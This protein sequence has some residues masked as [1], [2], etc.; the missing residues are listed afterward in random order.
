MPTMS[1]SVGSKMKK[2]VVARS[3]GSILYSNL[4][5]M[6]YSSLS[7]KTSPSYGD[8]ISLFAV[9]ATPLEDTISINYKPK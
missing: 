4:K 6:F 9:T 8:Y 2:V 7:N 3:V 5:G 1:S